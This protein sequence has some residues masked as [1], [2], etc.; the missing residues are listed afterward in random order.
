MS[1]IDKITDDLLNATFIWGD[2]NYESNV[3]T[4]GRAVPTI[5]AVLA[6][7]LQEEA[8]KHAELEAKSKK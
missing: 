1:L 7:S 2:N 8:T 4:S 3:I 5:K 6:S